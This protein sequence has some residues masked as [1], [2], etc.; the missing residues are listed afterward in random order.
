M[1]PTYDSTL[2]RI[3]KKTAYMMYLRVSIYAYNKEIMS[4]IVSI[5]VV[6]TYLPH[7]SRFIYNLSLYSETINIP[8]PPV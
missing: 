5:A 1:I 7:L 4:I 8:Q 6:Q 3:I 2:S